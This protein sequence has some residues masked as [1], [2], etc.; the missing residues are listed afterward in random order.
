MTAF[1]YTPEQVD[2]IENAARAI[3]PSALV[4]LSDSPL[5]YGLHVRVSTRMTVD[6]LIDDEKLASIDGEEILVGTVTAAAR[7]LVREIEKVGLRK[8]SM[9]LAAHDAI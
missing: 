3:I 9:I 6:T 1:T 7:Q 4:T 5:G 8:A 2:A